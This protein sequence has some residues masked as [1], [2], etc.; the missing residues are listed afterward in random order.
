MF[1]DAFV[2]HFFLL[3][4][5]DLMIFRLQ[6]YTILSIPPSISNFFSKIFFEVIE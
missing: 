6:N 2:L 4:M 3:F 5:I 1:N